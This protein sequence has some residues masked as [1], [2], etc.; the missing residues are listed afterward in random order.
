MVDF[1]ESIMLLGKVLEMCI[2]ILNTLALYIYEY[3]LCFL[4]FSLLHY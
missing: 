2:P 1:D 4:M 3:S